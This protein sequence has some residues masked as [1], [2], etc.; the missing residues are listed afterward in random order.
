MLLRHRYEVVELLRSHG[1]GSCLWA[2]DVLA[3]YK[4]PTV[5]FEFYL[6]IPDADLAKAV[7]ILSSTPGYRQPPPNETEMATNIPRRYFLQY[8]SSR[9]TNPHGRDDRFG[10]QLLPAIEFANF[11]IGPGTTVEHHVRLYP[12]LADFIESLVYQFLRPTG[13]RPGLA[14]RAHVCIYLGYLATHTPEGRTVLSVLSPK[15]RRLWGDFLNDEVI[16]GEKGFK[17]YSGA[18]SEDPKV[19][20][21]HSSL[22]SADDNVHV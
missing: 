13:E 8:W 19:I 11:T 1:V 4:V 16:N 21:H 18:E 9:F 2:E 14:Y 5:V 20:D 12:K 3:F 7:S 6:L 22:E 17:Y 10:I 15:A